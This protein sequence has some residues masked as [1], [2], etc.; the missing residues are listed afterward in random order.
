MISCIK[1]Y[2]LVNK[3]KKKKSSWLIQCDLNRQ[4][5][6]TQKQGAAYSMNQ[7]QVGADILIHLSSS[8]QNSIIL[9]PYF[10]ACVCTL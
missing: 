7:T 5:K 10:E 8:D 4:V 9:P 3:E 2:F 1:F 6:C